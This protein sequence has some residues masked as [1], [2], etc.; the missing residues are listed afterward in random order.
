MPQDGALT[1]VAT[2]RDE[3]I[4]PMSEEWLTD[5]STKGVA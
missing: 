1:A 5:S 3:V 2:Q 4:S